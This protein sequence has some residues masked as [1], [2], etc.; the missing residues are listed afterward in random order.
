MKARCIHG[1]HGF[2][3]CPHG[4]HNTDPVSDYEELE[5]NI[6]YFQKRLKAHGY[7]TK[8]EEPKRG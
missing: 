7:Y 8:P 5:R 3:R 4:C 1:Y 6:D 2:F